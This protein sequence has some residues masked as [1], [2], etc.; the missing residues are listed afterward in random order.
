MT[1]NIT[2]PANIST[3]N[4]TALDGIPFWDLPTSATWTAIQYNNT[5]WYVQYY[6]PLATYPVGM[7]DLLD[8]I[9]TNTIF[10][11]CSMVLT[12]IL[13]FIATIFL[14]RRLYS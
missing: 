12:S 5:T 9:A 1:F 7:K 6:T 8:Y 2:S 13:V 11:G 4:T 10:V 14:L 3:V